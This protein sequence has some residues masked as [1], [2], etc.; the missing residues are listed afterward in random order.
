VRRIRKE[1]QVGWVQTESR[2]VER[3]IRDVEAEQK[4]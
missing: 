1:E 2:R 3:R 4:G